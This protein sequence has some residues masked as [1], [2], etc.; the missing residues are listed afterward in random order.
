MAVFNSQQSE[1]NEQNEIDVIK[2]IIGKR[3]LCVTPARIFK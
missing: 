1:K 2:P 3:L